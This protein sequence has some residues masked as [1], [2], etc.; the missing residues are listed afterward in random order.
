MNDSSTASLI[1][2]YLEAV[3][4]IGAVLVALFAQVYLVR[5]RR[6]VLWLELHDDTAHEDLVVTA[7]S[8][9]TIVEYWV[10]LRVVA[11]AG[12]R[13]A[14]G[15]LV[16]L[17]KAARL[18]D[19]ESHRPSEANESPENLPEAQPE[20]SETACQPKTPVPSGPM[21]WSSLGETPQSILSGMW[22]RVD[23]LRY[24]HKT[25]KYARQLEIEVG[26]HFDENDTQTVLQDPGR[27]SITMLLGADDA[28]TTR[29]ELQF[30]YFGLVDDDG[31]V[32]SI[33]SGLK[34]IDPSRKVRPRSWARFVG[35]GLPRRRPRQRLLD[36]ID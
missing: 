27:Y 19:T 21:I 5:R 36:N 15:A 17:E 18:G 24:R 28:E 22:L 35:R 13:T 34:L 3:G 14:V 26:Y 2:S 9:R 12:R 30:D 23:V 20:R 29:W 8:T 31:D 16:R 7:N 25:P 32:R 4:T 11:A 6:P 1:A 10:R 33:V